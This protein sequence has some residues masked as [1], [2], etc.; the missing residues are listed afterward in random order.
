MSTWTLLICEG[1]HD[2]AALLGW[3]C[4]AGWDRHKGAIRDLPEAIQKVYPTPRSVDGKVRTDK[5]PDYV[6]RHDAWI[7]IRSLNGVSNVLGRSARN[8]LDSV[9]DEVHAVGFFVDADDKGVA[10]RQQEFRD[11]FRTTFSHADL[12]Q[13]GGVIEG[14]PRLGLWV[15]PD[16]RSTG[17]LS[18]LLVQSF[19]LARPKV[20]GAAE[21][22][23][24]SV[25]D[26][27]AEMTAEN[28]LKL[29]LGTAG[30][31]DAPSEALASALRQGA[32]FKPECY[33]ISALQEMIAFIERLVI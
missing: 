3:L 2:Q 30:Q 17:T 26:E 7:E 25:D 19:R 21:A 6:H 12:A 5:A 15:A 24:L 23:A 29:I 10:G 32:W 27:L 9:R 13:S 4:A 16:G 22:F 1:A 14:A 28:R 8:L 18:E 20:L 11:A 33:S 31:V